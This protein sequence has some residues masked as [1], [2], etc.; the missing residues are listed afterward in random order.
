MKSL[1][2][3]KPNLYC[4]LDDQ[5]LPQNNINNAYRE[6]TNKDEGIKI[7]LLFRFCLMV[8]LFFLGW[9]EESAA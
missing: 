3:F 6:I 5:K 2:P 7:L 8:C 4:P 1:C 9:H